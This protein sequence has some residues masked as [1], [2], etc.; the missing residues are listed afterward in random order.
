MTR[1]WRGLAVGI[2]LALS[3]AAVA[4][5]ET[6]E[7]S[8]AGQ[9]LASALQ[10]LAT[11]IGIQVVFFSGATRGLDAP[12]LAGRYTRREALDALLAGTELR[13]VFLTDNAV[14]I[15][16]ASGTG[17]APPAA[18]AAGAAPAWRDRSRPEEQRAPSQAFGMDEIVVT[19]TASRVRTKFDSSVA[20]STYDRADIVRRAPTSTA[21]L[22]SAV[23]GFWVESTA[24]TTHGNVFARGIVQD[25]GY[26]YVGLIE[27][28]LPVYPV[29][30]LSFYNPDQFIRLSEGTQ[31]VEVVRGGTAPIFTTGAVGGTI[32]FI[33]QPPPRMADVRLKAA[34]TDFGSRTL[35][36][37]WGAP[38]SDR[39]SL[40]A[41]G[42]VRRSDGLRDPGY[43][44]D[45][46]GQGRIEVERAAAGSR[47]GLYASHLDDRS[48]FVVPI[49]LRGN[50]SHPVAVDGTPA[51]EY[52]LHSADI[53]A[54]GLPPSAAEVGL[55]DSDLADGIH[56][57]LST[58]GVRFERY[59]AAGWTLASHARYTHGDVS[60]NGLFT[61]D[62][63]VTGVE[64]ARERGVAPD[65]RYLASD[66]PFDPDF[67][68]QNHGHWA[69]AKAYRA[70]QNDTRLTLPAGAHELTVGFYAA[71]FAMDDRWS[72]G[73]LILTDVGDRPERLFLPGVT[74]PAGFTRYSFLNLRAGYD[75]RASALFVSDEWDAT[76][77]LRVDLGARYDRQ[78]LDGEI[79]QGT[80]PVDLDG[81]PATTYDLAALAGDERER[82][83]GDF[84]YLSWSLGFNYDM[85]E[86]Q[87]LFGHL[88]RSAK[89]PHFDDLRNG[90]LREDRVV[91][92]EL[93]Y[94]ASLERLAIFLTAYGTVFDNVPFT[95]ILADGS[96]VVRRAETRT[97]GIEL[98]GVYE[99][100][101]SVS[102]EFSVTLQHPEYRGFT[103]TSIDNSGNRVRR[104]PRS[105]LRLEPSLAFA[106]GRGRAYVALAHYGERYAN[107]ENTIR[108]PSYLEVDAG[109]EY[110]FSEAWS[111]QLNV[112]NLSNE[113]GL[114]EGNP[115]TDVGSSGIGQIY[116]ARPLF[117]RSLSLAV[118]YRFQ[119]G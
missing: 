45:R 25:G 109:V 118:R 32:N 93:G 28:G 72:L 84:D 27:D 59:G 66:E 37:Y 111:A 38:L 74:D 98:E 6:F 41:S 85:S 20:I 90:V 113:V 100:V 11:Q 63:P 77:R 26:R 1:G 95:D 89:L 48:L 2:L 108:L 97:F 49:P 91:N 80:T 86:E 119:P 3:L 106:D 94:K 54:A 29:F 56:P 82:V 115:R 104:I 15:Q 50:P 71:D 52:S 57:R 68:V 43:P 30:E 81:D 78:R 42:W 9:P 70:L 53:R 87:A 16:V 5:E 19:G 12:P 58:A 36:V 99:P 47:F 69:I 107:D 76:G 102:V 60:F 7:V 110:R 23:P 44:A 96:T 112:D 88:T 62:V 14:A 116:N 40:A 65:F 39:W 51:G 17:D 75:G 18:P 67:L 105:M 92:A 114:T 101:E 79:S 8:L 13:Y 73:N 83:S 35:D 55:A 4:E 21:D 33:N 34:L 22:L 61:G 117:G 31:R 10:E 24:G 103:G 46:G 64:F